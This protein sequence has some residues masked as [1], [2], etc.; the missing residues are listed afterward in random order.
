MDDYKPIDCEFYDE[1]ESS[2]TIFSK[3]NIFYCSGKDKIHVEGKIVNIFIDHGVEYL[4][5]NNGLEIRL[6][7]I[8]SIDGK[9]NPSLNSKFL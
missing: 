9:Q 2:S 3:S 6:D 7:E 5:L 8:I 4:K 1:L